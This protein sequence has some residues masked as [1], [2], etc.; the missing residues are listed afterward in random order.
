MNPETLPWWKSRVIVGAGISALLKLI[1]ALL[2]LFG[3]PVEF[4]D[5]DLAPVID[6]LVLLVSFVGDFVAARGRI[7]QKVAPPITLRKEPPTCDT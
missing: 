6:A 4:A 3:H 1:F 7:T 2:V 5:E